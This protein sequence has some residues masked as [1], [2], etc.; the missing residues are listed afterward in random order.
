MLSLLRHS[1]HTAE[2]KRVIQKFDTRYG[3]YTDWEKAIIAAF[4]VQPTPIFSN[5]V[6]QHLR[7]LAIQRTFLIRKIYWSRPFPP[8][9]PSYLLR[10]LYGSSSHTHPWCEARYFRFHRD[11]NT[12][13]PIHTLGTGQT[14]SPKEAMI[15]GYCSIKSLK[16]QRKPEGV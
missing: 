10:Y 15:Y 12:P 9:R 7:E 2:R 16:W 8:A 3:R 11:S 14:P 4:H 13:N 1:L 6:T 5:L